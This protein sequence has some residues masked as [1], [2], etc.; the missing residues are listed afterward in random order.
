MI[1]S[2]FFSTINIEAMAVEEGITPPTEQEETSSQP[3]EGESGSQ[4]EE[5]YTRSGK[6]GANLLY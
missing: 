4:T 1:L 2:L 6:L 3:S 5:E